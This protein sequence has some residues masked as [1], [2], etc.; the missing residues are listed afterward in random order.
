MV[1]KKPPPSTIS[2]VYEEAPDRPFIPV[3]GA[4][5]GAA[6][7]G[8]SVV[9][10]LYNEYGSLPTGSQHEVGPDGEVDLSKGTPSRLSDVTRRVGATLI[11]S[12]EA[13]IRLGNWLVKH[14]ADATEHRKKNQPEPY[15]PPS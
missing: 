2:I 11:L 4:F 13:A 8:T 14:G 9:A 7:D 5:G 12:P 10:H 1:D 3:G 15:K 6:P